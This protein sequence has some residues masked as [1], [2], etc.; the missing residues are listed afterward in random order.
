MNHSQSESSCSF[1]WCLFRRLHHALAS[2]RAQSVGAQRT[3]PIWPVGSER[4]LMAFPSRSISGFC[5]LTLSLRRNHNRFGWN[6]WWTLDIR[7]YTGSRSR[8]LSSLAVTNV[9]LVLCRS[10]QLPDAP[11]A[12]YIWPGGLLAG[13]W[14]RAFSLSCGPLW[15]TLRLRRLAAVDMSWPIQHR[16]R[17]LS[18]VRLEKSRRFGAAALALQYLLR[19]TGRIPGSPGYLLDRPHPPHRW[20]VAAHLPPAVLRGH[21]RLC[22]A[23]LGDT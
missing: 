19:E 13:N 18:D 20:S 16:R 8:S 5:F 17:C 7:L 15:G 14:P 4:T 10:V 9:T 11:A 12:L 3:D 6:S 2:L 23:V 21:R 22:S 1:V